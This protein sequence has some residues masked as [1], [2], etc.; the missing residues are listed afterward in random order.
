[1]VNGVGLKSNYTKTLTATTSPSDIQNFRVGGKTA[2]VIR[3]NWNKNTTAD[4]YIIEQYKN[5][6]WVRVT[7]LSSNATT[8]YR[9]TGLKSKTTYKFRMKAYNMVGSTGLYS[10]VTKTITVTTS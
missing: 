10:N 1:M 2:S 6:K 7:K 3:L 4:G 9:V 8:T 5:G